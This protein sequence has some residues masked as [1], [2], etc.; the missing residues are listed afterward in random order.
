M[1]VIGTDWSDLESL[2]AKHTVSE[3]AEIKGSSEANVRHV[4]DRRGLKAK[5]ARVIN[6]PEPL[7]IS[8]KLKCSG[9]GQ[10]ILMD[11]KQARQQLRKYRRLATHFQRFKEVYKAML[12]K[13]PQVE[14]ELIVSG[15]YHKE[16]SHLVAKILATARKEDIERE[17][18]Q[19]PRKLTEEQW[20]GILKEHYSPFGAVE[21]VIL[22]LIMYGLEDYER[23]F[24][25][26]CWKLNKL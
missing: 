8:E 26:N 16:A 10:R 14:A 5:P 9:C 2:A 4:L 11:E 19:Y 25:E 15:D 1:K 23:I 3:I 18:L 20:M 21:E 12:D 22:P 6:P 7:G 13:Q 24:I 17:N